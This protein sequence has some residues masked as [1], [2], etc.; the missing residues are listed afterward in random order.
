MKD[1]WGSFTRTGRP[2]AAGQP[3]WPAYGVAQQT[4]DLRPGGASQV[5][6]DARISTAHQC[7]FW[8]GLGS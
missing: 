4:M 7:G 2:V 3:D 6:S 5:V 1:D 8:A